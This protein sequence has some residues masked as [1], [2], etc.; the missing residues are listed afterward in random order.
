MSTSTLM[1]LLASGDRTQL[2]A[3]ARD[4]GRL[5]ST[6]TP[7]D[8]RDTRRDLARVLDSTE[9][10]HARG[11]IE[12]LAMVARGF[13]AEGAE[14]QLEQA[15]ASKVAARKHWAA[16]LELA[17]DGRRLPRELAETLALEPSQV[18]R[19]LDE[20]E[21]ADLMVRTA[22]GAGEDGRTR[23]FRLSPKGRATCNQ[24]RKH[25]PTTSAPIA[26][27]IESVVECMAILLASGR[28]SRSK[29]ALVL[30]QRLDETVSEIAMEHLTS[31]L[32][33][34]SL[35]VLDTD[36]SL[37]AA[38]MEVQSHLDRVVQGA[39]D[40]DDHGLVNWLRDL[41]KEQRLFV[42]ATNR[43]DE[44]DVLVQRSDLTNVRV[45][46][47]D[48]LVPDTAGAVIGAYG[49]LYES[50][51]LLETDR[52]NQ[53]ATKLIEAAQSRHVFAVPPTITPDGFDM[54]TLPLAFTDSSRR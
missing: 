54:V 12:G 27:L 46:R 18:T 43:G 42:R 14:N 36:D 28:A 2:A 45:I 6:T 34:T 9:D 51:V 44:W 26:A 24:L 3:A 20:L 4:F 49:V 23:P 47:D 32:A 22:P 17:G 33:G 39:L 19:I 11:V 35:A 29:L 41:S 13:E 21:D 1:S 25:K 48:D 16:I 5:L 53:R 40:N 30:E 38:G 15:A 31:A 50:A 52:R 7:T 37:L 8:L 10:A